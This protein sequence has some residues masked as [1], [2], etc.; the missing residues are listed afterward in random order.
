[1]R[2]MSVSFHFTDLSCWILFKSQVT[3]VVYAKRARD[4]AFSVPGVCVCVFVSCRQRMLFNNLRVPH[5]TLQ[6]GVV[7]ASL[8]VAHITMCI[9]LCGRP[10]KNGM[11]SWIWL[12]FVGVE[13]NIYATGC[14]WVDILTM[15]SLYH[16]KHYVGLIV[17]WLGPGLVWTWWRTERFLTLLDTEPWYPGP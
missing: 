14:C 15:P 2:P 5:V 16:I 4:G 8:S 17:G 12:T 7:K 1:M 9:L 10:I 6:I 11:L 13:V 3:H